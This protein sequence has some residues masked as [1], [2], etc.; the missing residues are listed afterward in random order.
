[1]VNG[2]DIKMITKCWTSGASRIREWPLKNGPYFPLLCCNL[3]P[4]GTYLEVPGGSYF[5][6][7]P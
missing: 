5:M 4:L 7:L 1:M 3:A 2:F 6:F